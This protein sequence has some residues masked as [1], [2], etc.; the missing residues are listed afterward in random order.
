MP[1]R[2]PLSR[3]RYEAEHPSVTVRIPAEVKAQVLAAAKAADV[4]RG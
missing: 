4:C 3:L 1:R 2:K